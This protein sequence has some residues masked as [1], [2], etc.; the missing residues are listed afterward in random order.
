MRDEASNWFAAK[1]VGMGI[2]S[3]PSRTRSTN[4]FLSASQKAGLPVMAGNR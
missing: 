4:T 1:T 3:P 2:P